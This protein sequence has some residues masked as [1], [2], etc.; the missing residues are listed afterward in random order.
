ML[1]IRA[2]HPDPL[3]RVRGRGDKSMT[4]VSRWDHRHLYPALASLALGMVAAVL[5]RGCAGI[6]LGL[7]FGGVAFATLIVPPLVAGEEH[8][9]RRWL[10]P[11]GVSVGTAAVWLTALGE[12]LT[13]GQWLA[14]CVA[15]VAYAAALCGITSFL[16]AARFNAVLAAG[17]VTVAALLWLTWPVWLSPQLLRPSGDAI[18]SWLVPAH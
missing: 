5:C 2:P 18:V 13:F 15:L 1:A 6:S 9:V 7:F 8:V 16:L 10:V 12:L 3:P 17:V 11:V 4:P 14:C